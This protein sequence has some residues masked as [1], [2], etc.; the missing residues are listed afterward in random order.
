MR[1]EER[2]I[3]DKSEIDD[4]IRR[5]R[6]CRLGMCDSGQPYIVPLCFGFDG[7]ALY[8][9][10]ARIGRKLD[11]IRANPNVCFEIDIDHETITA[12]TS[13]KWSMRYRSIIGFG[14][15]S[16]IEDEEEIRKGLDVI[17]RQFTDQSPEYNNAVI[18]K[19]RII[20]VQISE[21]TAEK[22]GY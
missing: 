8:F 1:R 3:T 13:C 22:F 9:H 10:C 12:D 4:I 21:L 11:M 18:P 19:T 17:M 6:V 14:I 7:D 20:R 5:A 16:I 15:A 2:R